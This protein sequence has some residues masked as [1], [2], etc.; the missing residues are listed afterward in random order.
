MECNTPSGMHDEVKGQA[1]QHQHDGTQECG[2]E[3]TNVKSRNEGAGQQQDDGVDDQKEQAQGQ[4][5]EREGQQFKKESHSGIQKADNQG[6]DQRTAEAGKLKAWHDIGADKKGNGAE[7]P[8][9]K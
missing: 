1:D 9:E 3:A 2:A 4:N 8:N 5:A 6:R 7:Q